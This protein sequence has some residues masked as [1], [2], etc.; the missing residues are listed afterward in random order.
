MSLIAVAVDAMANS[1]LGTFVFTTTQGFKAT[2]H[3]VVRA[4]VRN[5]ATAMQEAGEHV[6][7]MFTEGDPRR[8]VETRL[9]AEG[10]RQE[11]RAQLQ[12]HGLGGVQARRYD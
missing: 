4:R 11:L 8:T 9:A 3:A 6:G 1:K 2:S 12:S 7:S 10:V 5:I